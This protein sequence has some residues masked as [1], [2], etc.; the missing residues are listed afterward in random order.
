MRVSAARV[1]SDRPATSPK[2]T[3]A[4]PSEKKNPM[5]IGRRPWE[6]SL[7]VVLSIAAM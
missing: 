5:P 2:T 1:A 7:R 6:R 3:L 4:W